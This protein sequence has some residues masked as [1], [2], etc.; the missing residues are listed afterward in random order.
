MNMNK[1]IIF[2]ILL[3][4]LLSCESIINSV[5]FLP[6]N[7]VAF[8][9]LDNNETE[10]LFRSFVIG[11]KNL[12]VFKYAMRC[13]RKYGFVQSFKGLKQTDSKI[14]CIFT[15]SVPQVS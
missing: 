4:L 14:L 15:I 8:L 13:Q 6:D 2:I 12:V 1:P 10:R 3:P 9:M 5:S 11:R 7:S